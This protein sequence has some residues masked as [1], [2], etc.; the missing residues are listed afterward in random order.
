MFKENGNQLKQLEIKE[1]IFFF[2]KYILKTV[3]VVQISWLFIIH[4]HEVQSKM[5]TQSKNM[6][7]KYHVH[8]NP[9]LKR[10]GEI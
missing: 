6:I 1:S 5:C 9:Y 3:H 8:I 4:A 7:S 10:T 2:F